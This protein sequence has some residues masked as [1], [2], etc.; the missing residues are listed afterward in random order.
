MT[1]V[2]HCNTIIMTKIKIKK[3]IWNDWNKEHIKKHG[4]S[5]EEAEESGKNFKYHRKT[6][7]NRYLA[8]GRSGNRIL[9]LIINRQGLG[10]YYLV[11]A[12]DADKK[13][14]KKLY[15]KEL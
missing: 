14:R 2:L 15:D 6:K 3:L 5:V 10:V 9:T 13:E 7:E 8:V 12:R 11:T 1:S 4:V